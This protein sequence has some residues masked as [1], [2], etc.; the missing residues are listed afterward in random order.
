MLFFKNT[1]LR[2]LQVITTA[3]IKS[4]KSLHQKKFREESGLFLVEGEKLLHELLHSEW[5]IERICATSSWLDKNKIN[6]G[7][8]INE[9][10]SSELERISALTQPNE[11]LAVVRQRKFDF[12]LKTAQNG[13]TILLD[14]VRDPGNLGTIIRIADWFGV[15]QIVCSPQSV[16]LFNPKTIQSTMGSAFRIPVVYTDLLP[17]VH[18]LKKE[19]IAICGA[20]MEG[21]NVLSFEWK[22]STAL[23][24]GSESHGINARLSALLDEHVTI[25]RFGEAESL[26][27]SVATGIFCAM[28]NRQFS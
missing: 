10:K 19:G 26:N 14:D 1:R 16:E 12:N 18:D 6:Q 2:P 28:F 23:V 17:L 13:L 15:R 21:K 11:V 7:I 27:V 22:K 8:I 24:M 4:V 5:E 9:V 20:V 25:P 3:E